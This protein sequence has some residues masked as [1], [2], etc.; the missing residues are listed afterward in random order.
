[1]FGGVIGL[2]VP[3]LV[4]PSLGAANEPTKDSIIVFDTWN[5][6]TNNFVSWNI[7]QPK[8]ERRVHGPDSF[9]RIYEEPI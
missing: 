7:V 5:Q 1:M 8:L 2:L 6:G 4:P 9:R 3:L